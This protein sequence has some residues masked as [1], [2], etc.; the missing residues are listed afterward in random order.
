MR[1]VVSYVAYP[2]L[3][4]WPLIVCFLALRVFVLPGDPVMRK[5][6]EVGLFLLSAI[7]VVLSLI[8]LEKHLPYWPERTHSA[9]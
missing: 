8:L 1:R 5:G 4:S 6:I 2:A 7:P 9:T 3:I